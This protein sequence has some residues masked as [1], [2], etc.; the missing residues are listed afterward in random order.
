MSETPDNSV[1]QRIQDLYAKH[2][3][4]YGRA[5]YRSAARISRELRQL[6]KSEGRVIT[7]LHANHQLMNSAQSLLEPNFGTEVAIDS[8]ALLESEE[9]ARLMQPSLPEDQYQYAVHRMS[10]CAYDNLAKHIANRDGY[11]SDGVHDCITD[12][13]QV[14]RRTGKLECINCFREYATDVYKASDDLE[15]AM[16]HATAVEQ[17]TP[18]DEDDDRRWVGA[19]DQMHLHL[20]QG[21]L[22]AALNAA[23]RCWLLHVNFHAKFEAQLDTLVNL[24]AIFWMLGKQDEFAAFVANAGVEPVRGNEIPSGEF[25]RWDVAIGQRDALRHACRGEFTEALDLLTRLDQ[26]LQSRQCL[27]LW[28]EGRLRLVSVCL[29]A[30]QSDKA[31]RLA[32]QLEERAKPARDWLTLR[33]LKALLSG[34]LLPAPIPSVAAYT[35][36]PFA[37][38]SSPASSNHQHDHDH[39]HG[40][41]HHHD[42][43]SNS[44]DDL[45]ESIDLINSPSAESPQQASESSPF[46]SWLEDWLHR[47]SATSSDDQR[48]AI[49]FEL[50]D[51]TALD[52]QTADEAARLVHTAHVFIA[53]FNGEVQVWNWAQ[54]F[55]DAFANDPTLINVVASLGM[56]ARDAASRQ[57]SSSSSSD[58]DNVVTLRR[59]EELFLKS[60]DLDADRTNNFIRAGQFYWSIDRQGDAERCFSRAFRLDR[61]SSLAVMRLAEIYSATDRAQ[62][63]LSVLDLSIREGC[64]D[65]PVF[66]QAAMTAI[67]LSRY[68]VATSYLLKY[69]KLT[70]EEQWVHYYLALCYLE[71]GRPVDALRSLDI[72]A[73]RNPTS[74]YATSALRVCAAALGNNLPV[75]R[76][77]L[78]TLLQLRLSKVNYLTQ[79]GLS[80]LFDRLYSAMYKLPET[81]ELR[82]QLELVGLQAGFAPDIYFDYFRQ[83]REAQDDASFYVVTLEQSLPVDWPSSAGCLVGQEKW[84]S[85]VARWGVL[86]QDV[87]QAEQFARDWQM[88]CSLGPCELIAIDLQSDGYK[89]KLGVVWQGYHVE[90]GSET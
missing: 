77:H 46:L 8:I 81:D 69:E 87:T 19:R 63:A 22:E 3:E 43:D 67:N 42:H 65:P 29:M 62:D 1:D 21:Q 84:Q 56:T 80:R 20:L 59:L 41:C 4:L 28:F 74:P 60:L 10:S 50:L 24:E 66:W 9:K 72:E 12:G 64:D 61:T 27:D 73:E 68:Q 83:Q 39:D 90:Q 51:R 2:A 89:D 70:S 49:A 38:R 35:S 44:N 75:L 15:M 88:R 53:Q 13:I 78:T 18:R 85:Y 33:R 6:A 14:C 58:P 71:T 36:G 30:G 79:T 76:E 26:L 17:A 45:I 52:P 5:H 54:Q 40:Q 25:P 16:H 47:L 37:P 11:N 82:Q 34:E 7:Y 31:A 55:L 57:D 32:K 86:A 23:K 48:R